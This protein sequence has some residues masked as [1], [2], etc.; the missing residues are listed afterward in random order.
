MAYLIANI[1][2]L[3]WLVD[4]DRTLPPVV[5]EMW[6]SKEF[7]HSFGIPSSS[8]SPLV[9]GSAIAGLDQINRA[10]KKHYIDVCQYLPS[11]VGSAL[12]DSELWF[13]VHRDTLI[14]G[15]FRDIKKCIELIR[16]RHGR[17][18]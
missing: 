14:I 10:V 16:P 3:R 8:A 12:C 6:L 15:E 4:P 5:I 11:T 18:R 17:V 13:L 1:S 9:T 2:E 7:T